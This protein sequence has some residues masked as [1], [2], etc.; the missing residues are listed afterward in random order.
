[1][2]LPKLPGLRELRG[3]KQNAGRRLRAAL[4]PELRDLAD[5]AHEHYVAWVGTQMLVNEVRDELHEVVGQLDRWKAT[6]DSLENREN[7]LEVLETELAEQ[8]N[9]VD[10]AEGRLDDIEGYDLDTMQSTLEEVEELPNE[11][12]DLARRVQRLEEIRS[13]LRELLTD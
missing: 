3:L 5:E 7:R 4:V 1:M 8:T 11:W 6:A 2:K 9:R 13:K 12:M 10:D